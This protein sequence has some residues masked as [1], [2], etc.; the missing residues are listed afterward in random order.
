MGLMKVTLVRSRAIDYAVNKVAISLAQNGYDVKLL[1]WD[2]GG[3]ITE[4]SNG[5]TTCRFGLKAPYDKFTVLFYLPLWWLYEFLFLMRD[6]SEIIHACDL[7]TLLPALVV[8]TV[9]RNKLFY[10]IYDFYANNLPDGQPYLARALLR[11]WIAAIEKLGISFTDVLF[12]VDESRY[13]EVK[14][15]RIN[16]LVYIYNSPPDLFAQ[17][18]KQELRVESE[19]T[20]FYAGLIHKSRGLEYMIQAIE[21]LDG[22]K[23]IIGGTGTDRAFV[24]KASHECEKIRYIGWIP[25]Y[26]E[27]IRM[28][29]KADVLF[30]FIDPKIPKSKYESPNKLFEA[31]MCGKP[32]IVSDNSSMA[33]IVRKENCGIVVPYGIVIAIKGA[34][35]KLKNNPDLRKKLGENGRRAYETEYNWIIMEG[36]LLDAYKYIG[37]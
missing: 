12:L 23:L 13:E 30:R 11:K 33:C 4:K 25:S 29:T 34:I 31:M 24:E 2:R 35:I 27:I 28:T 8:K 14:G 17:K 1:V 9:K 22:V 37:G 3:H 16:K 36:R 21:D 15:A 26:E 6:E 20:V 18:R 10:T 32:I 19:L 7:D 5:Y